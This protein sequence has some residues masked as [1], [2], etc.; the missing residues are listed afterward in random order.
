ME[1]I[2]TVS[3]KLYDH[4]IIGWPKTIDNARELIFSDLG[5][6]EKLDKY[7]CVAPDFEVDDPSKGGCNQ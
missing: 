2:Y 3:M 6:D 5:Q 1:E 7:E 4:R